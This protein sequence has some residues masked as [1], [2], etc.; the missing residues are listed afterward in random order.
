MD[1]HVDQSSVST[2]GTG[3]TQGHTGGSRKKTPV[4]AHRDTSP[5]RR[6]EF[7]E[8][9]RDNSGTE[10]AMRELSSQIGQLSLNM[11]HIQEDVNK[12]K[13]GTGVTRGTAPTKPIV[14]SV[15]LASDLSKAEAETFVCL[16]SG[17]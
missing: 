15:D 13:S 12:I 17:A 1:K 7:E 10:A 9:P 14:M 4:D 3:P 5:S 16:P 8:T 11:L 2:G 6:L